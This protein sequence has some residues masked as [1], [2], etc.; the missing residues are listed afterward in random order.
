MPSETNTTAGLFFE[1][2]RIIRRGIDRDKAPLSITQFEAVRFIDERQTPSMRDLALHLHITAPS[3]TS[4]TQELVRAGY[5]ERASDPQDRR[6]IRLAVTG[7]GAR[8]LES[9]VMRRKAVLKRILLRLSRRDHQD[10]RRIF[11]K[12]IKE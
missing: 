6:Q 9:T 12:I 10:L 8:A 5:V 7:K 2:G 11:L 3:T 1:A 4:L